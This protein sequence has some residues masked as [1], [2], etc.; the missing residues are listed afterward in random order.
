[1]DID[2]RFVLISIAV[3]ILLI[4]IIPA[5]PV[6]I[7]GAILVVIFGF[8]FSAVSSRMVGLV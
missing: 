1:M 7:F 5:I 4:W 2:M 6:T 3:L 8:F